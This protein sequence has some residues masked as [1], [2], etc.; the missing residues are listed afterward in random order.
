MSP[1][2]NPVGWVQ[3]KLRELGRAID[4][5]SIRTFQ[6]MYYW[7]ILAAGCYLLFAASAPPQLIE[8]TLISPAYE[9]WLLANIFCPIMTFAGR[10]MYRRAATVAEGEPN[11]ARA[12]ALF[13]IAGDGGVWAAICIYILCVINTAWWGQGLY[14][15]FFVLMGIPGG[16]MFTWRSVRRFRQ[17]K[18]REAETP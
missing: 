1:L 18:R 5:E 7:F 6:T 10:R 12:G 8:D 4:A 2:L 11:A 16:A 15:A 13:Q 9:F 14:A 17:I 3:E